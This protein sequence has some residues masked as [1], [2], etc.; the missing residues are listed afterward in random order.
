[1][2]GTNRRFAKA[3]PSFA[4]G[5]GGFSLLRPASEQD[6][7]ILSVKLLNAARPIFCELT[8]ATCTG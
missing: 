7:I 1:M 5:E 2:L 6:R 8:T 4:S 3:R